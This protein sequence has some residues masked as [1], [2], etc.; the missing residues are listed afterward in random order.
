LTECYFAKKVPTSINDLIPEYMTV[1][2][3][4]LDCKVDILLAETIST[5]REALAILRS[6][7]G[8]QKLGNHH[9]PPLWISLTIHDNR[10]T[11][12]RSDEALEVACQT[13][14]REANSLDLPL[15]AI[16]VN[17]SAPSAI[18]IAVPILA[19]IVVGTKIKVCAYG[20]C[21][22][23]TTSEWMNSLDEDSKGQEESCTKDEIKETDYDGEGYLT[24]DAYAKYA[25]K[26][27]ESGATVIGGC[28]GSRPKHMYAVVAALRNV[29]G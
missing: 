13:I 20:N 12:L 28:C 1:V 22:R 8:I 29:F 21:F 14:I 9:I 10:P 7:S 6:I 26:F 19:K 5:A 15:E 24:P 27:V 25:S 11:K 23:T 17:C 4:L 2:S 3:T 18:S 16:G